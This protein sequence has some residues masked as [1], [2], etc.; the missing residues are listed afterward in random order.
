MTSRKVLGLIAAAALAACGGSSQSG[1]LP[2]EVPPASTSSAAVQEFMAGVADSNLVRIGSA[3]GTSDGSAAAR[4]NPSDWLRRV[5][6]MQLWLRGG[7]YTI[8]S[9]QA[10]NAD[11][12]HRQVTISLVRGQCTKVVPFTVVQVK[13]GWLVENVDLNQAGN[14]A[15][16]C[17]PDN[18]PM[19]DAGGRKN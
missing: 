2:G 7:T 1:T 10:I 14:P 16:P 3:W 11:R 15:Q 4:N 19:P 5:T 17:G 6:V 9:D 8:T 18:G 13:H 12:T